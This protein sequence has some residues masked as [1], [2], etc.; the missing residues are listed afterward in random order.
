MK[1]NKKKLTT[2]SYQVAFVKRDNDKKIGYV[3]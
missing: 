3:I 1:N 2:E